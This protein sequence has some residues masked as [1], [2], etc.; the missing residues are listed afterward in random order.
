M[1]D[2]PKPAHP[3]YNGDISLMLQALTMLCPLSLVIRFALIA[4]LVS[5]GS[6]QE[7]IAKDS[8]TCVAAVNALSIEDPQASVFNEVVFSIHR[9]GEPKL[10]GSAMSSVAAINA[11]LK[12]TGVCDDNDINKYQTET[13]LTNMFESQLATGACGATDNETAPEGLFGFC[14]MSLNRTV[15]QPDH[16]ELVPTRTGSLPCRLFTREGRRVY[17]L[18]HLT[19]LVEAAKEAGSTCSKEDEATC[20]SGPVVD[21]YAV[22]A[23][24]VF[25]FAASYVGE[26]FVVDH[27]QENVPDKTIVL[28]VISVNPRIFE[29]Y[30]FFSHD[31]SDE[32]IDKALNDTS[33]T[34][35]LHR[36]TTGA[37]NGQVFSKRTSDNAWDTDGAVS[38]RIQRRCFEMLGLDEYHESH[39]DGLQVSASICT[40]LLLI[41]RT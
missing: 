33:E 20:A 39:S 2:T 3:M 38:L 19:R 36:S 28:E 35:G 31:E 11:A 25:M 14:D 9:N 23:G 22:P 24:R 26:K 5:T 8:A 34:H 41:G 1:K 40:T 18:Q 12:S 30:N 16:D 37:T 27:V 29:I 17:S 4:L 13:F 21:L 32:I 10:C 6:A 7:S 15:I